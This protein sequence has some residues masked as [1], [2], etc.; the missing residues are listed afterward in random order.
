MIV[1]M[2]ASNYQDQ[3]FITEVF[4]FDLEQFVSKIK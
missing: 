1:W 2:E 3:E 4:I